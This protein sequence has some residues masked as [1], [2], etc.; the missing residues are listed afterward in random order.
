MSDT[1]QNVNSEVNIS[2]LP[3]IRVPLGAAS[4]GFF[5]GKER[6]INFDLNA[7]ALMEETYGSMEEVEKVLN[8]GNMKSIRTVLWI[9]L[10]WD[11]AVIDPITGEP[12]KY[13]LTPYQVGS[14][15]NANNMKDVISKI[16]TAL[17]NSLP[18]EGVDE[19]TEAEKAARMNAEAAEAAGDST[20]SFPNA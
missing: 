7:F 2:N 11:E 15:L 5:D 8:S 17:S 19:E 3:E 20:V 1:T 10:V 13:N 14:W 16:S 18:E 12:T 9:G 4:I 6:Y